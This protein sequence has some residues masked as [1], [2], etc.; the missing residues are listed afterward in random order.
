VV[1][2]LAKCMEGATP[3]AFKEMQHLM[4]FVFDT[5]KFGL[6]IKTKL[7]E[8]DNWHMK[9]YIDSDWAGEKEN[10]RSVTGYI[11]FLCGVPIIWKSKLQRT[12]SLSSIV[13]AYYALS[14]AAKEVKFI[15]QVLLT[16]NNQVK[17]PVIVHVDNVGAIFMS[18]NVTASSRTKHIDAQYHFVHEYT[19]DGFTKIVFVKS[20]DKHADIF[21]KYVTV[22]VISMINMY[23][24]VLCRNHKFVRNEFTN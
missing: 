2:E 6:M 14:E 24:I 22:Q 7:D 18:E 11:M 21:T 12:V 13:A 10:Q 9:M 23:K 4:K 5:K 3:A 15:V 19:E 20:D 8:N 1:R 17:L 16:I